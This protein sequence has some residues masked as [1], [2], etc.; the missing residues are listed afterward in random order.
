MWF[1]A[2]HFAAHER[3]CRFMERRNATW[4]R[5]RRVARQQPMFAPPGYRKKLLADLE[6][7]TEAGLV[8]RAAADTIAAE[9]RTDAS[10]AILT[11]LAFVFAILGAGGLIALVAANWNEIPREVR[12]ASLLAINLVALGACLAFRLERRP[13]SLAIECAAAL[14]AMSAAA[15]IALV[16]QMYHLPSNWPGFGLALMC[17]A[18]ATALAARST[19][20]L[21]LA[22][23]AQ[24]GYLAAIDTERPGRGRLVDFAAGPAQ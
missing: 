22:A 17:I 2:L 12:L 4:R 7:C 15:T 9:C 13:G 20:C 6:R 24:L 19:A 16:G 18:G 23:A 5:P 8:S 10:H 11:V 14:S 3:Q 21:W 1:F